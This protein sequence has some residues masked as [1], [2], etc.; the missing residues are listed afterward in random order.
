MTRNEATEKSA[1]AIAKL[2]V[3]TATDDYWKSVPGIREAA[4]KIVVSLVALGLLKLS[5]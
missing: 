3:P 2:Q 5:D 1:R 4:E